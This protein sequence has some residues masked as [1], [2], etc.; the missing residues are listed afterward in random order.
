MKDILDTLSPYISVAATIVIAYMTFLNTRYSAQAGQEKMRRE[1]SA[2]LRDDLL[3]TIDSCTKR[4]DELGK[5][6]QEQQRFID[7]ER[8]KRRMWETENDHLSHQIAR[9]KTENDELQRRIAHLE[10]LLSKLQ[11]EF[12][13]RA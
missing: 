9:L 8:A 3:Q 1:D 6:N 2:A 4:N 10:A 11:K 7:E 5:L 13:K 12:E